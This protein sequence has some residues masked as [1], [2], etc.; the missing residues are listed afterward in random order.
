MNC[1]KITLDTLYIG[2]ISRW[3]GHYSATVNLIYRDSATRFSTSGFMDQFQGLG[4]RWFMKKSRGTV[5]LTIK[6][7][8]D[9]VDMVRLPQQMQRAMAAEAEA[10]REARAKVCNR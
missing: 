10:T 6:Y 4:G 7:V 3:L 5:P 9:T 8:T 2:L 1:H